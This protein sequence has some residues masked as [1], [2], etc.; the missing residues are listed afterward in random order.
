MTTMVTTGNLLNPSAQGLTYGMFPAGS[1]SQYLDANSVFGNTQTPYNIGTGIATGGVFGY[2]TDST[3]MIA[4]NNAYYDYAGVNSD[5]AT[6]LAFKQRSNAHTLNSYSEIMQKNLTEM[7]TAIREGEFGKASSIY[8]EIYSAISKNYGEELVTQEQR[9]EA[10][11]S[12]KATITNLY[13]QINGAALTTDID[14]AGEGYFTNGF[15]QGLTLGNHH[16]N[17]A[18]ETESYMTGSGIENYSG[19][20]F[21]KNAGKV[22]GGAVSVGSAA[23]I[24]AAIGACFGGPIV[25]AVVGGAIA[26]GTWLF[27]DNSPEKVTKA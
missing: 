22:L 9:V 10:D 1:L 11:Q 17:S 7:A 27:S 25:G 15:M 3:S 8:N 21:Q 19:K 4:N 16:K 24:G 18:E 12:I 6:S 14:E 26:L 2:G 13:Q 23:G 5:N 20:K